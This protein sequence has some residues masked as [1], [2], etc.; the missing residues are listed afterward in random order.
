MCP[1]EPGSHPDG[2][3]IACAADRA[4]GVEP[5]AL[6]G[7]RGGPRR[8]TPPPRRRPTPAGKPVPPCR[9]PPGRAE[10]DAPV[11][12]CGGE[13]RSRTTRARASSHQTAVDRHYPH[14]IAIGA[15]HGVAAGSVR[16]CQPTP[17]ACSPRTRRATTYESRPARSSAGVSSGEDRA[18]CGQVEGSCTASATWTPG[19]SRATRKRAAARSAPP[20]VSIRGDTLCAV[21]DPSFDP[22]ADAVALA[23]L[24][25]AWWEYRQNQKKS[26]PLSGS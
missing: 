15:G 25:L 1:G 6:S 9:R 12:R 20:V 13:A 16:A 24:L 26:A 4:E 10:P 19:W 2:S 22:V 8:T 7:S 17:I 11:G 21:L 18:T 3:F 14:Q 23:A 5:D